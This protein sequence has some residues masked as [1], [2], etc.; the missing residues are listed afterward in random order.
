ML[1]AGGCGLIAAASIAPRQFASTMNHQLASAARPALPADEARMQEN[2][3]RFR[4]LADSLPL[5]IWQMGMDKR[6]TY[7]NRSWLAFTGRSL[8]D[9]QRRGWVD[10]IHPQDR[11][12]C[13]HTGTRAFDNRRP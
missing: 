1:A 6:C 12:R 3:E 13:T 2:E 5:M 4:A 8:E 11:E 7:F 9:E 10:G